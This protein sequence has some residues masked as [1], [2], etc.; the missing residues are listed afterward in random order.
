MLRELRI[1]NFAVVESATVPFE[2]GLNVLTGE[3]G[4]GKSILLDALLL[5][6]GVRAQTDVI[7][8]DA[9]TA[10]VEAVFEVAPASAAATVVEEA[11]LALDDGLLVVRRELARNGRHRAFVSDSPVTVGLLE[12]LGDHL[13]EVHG[14]HEHQRLLEPAR[15]LDLLDRFAG[16]EDDRERVAELHGKFREAAAAVER[17]R[18]AERDRA[19]REDL[20]RLQINELDAARLR[21]GEEDEL[22]GERRRLQHAERFTTGLAEVTALLDEDDASARS[23]IDRAAR[24][25]ADLARLDPPFGAAAEPLEAARAHLEECLSIARRLR[26]QITFEP[27]RREAIDERLDA[28]ARLK[29]KYGDSEAAMLKFREEAAAELRRLERHDEVL[30]AEERVHAQ[31]GAELGAAAL[32]LSERRQAAAG[33]LGPRVQRELRALGM[34]RAVFAVAIERGEAASA[35]GLDRV[36]FR[37]AA[38]AGDAPAS[39]ARVASG[40]E[41]SRT[42]LALTAVL[43]ARDGVPT[44][45]FD[46]VDAGIGGGIAGVVGDKLAQAADGRQVLCVTHLAPIAARARHHLRVSKSVR[47]GRTRAAVVPLAGGERLTEIGRM[48]GG[49]PPSEA[50]LRH[51]RELLA[52][53]RARSGKGPA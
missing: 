34:E 20:L 27:G 24:V 44:L 26:E 23:R 35:R 51:A 21:P 28:L 48:L 17:T 7:R 3:T 14:Q 30:A 8:A 25:L 6:R 12:R 52:A 16:A 37:L 31:L 45:V 29:R 22:R 9:E 41:L 1:R 40:G 39:L 2:P 53:T 42:M 32:A 11:G 33:R 13:V 15:Q 50:A 49:D 4:A 46:E 19:Q 36:E 47:G 18:G 5:L 38:N 10:T 43:A